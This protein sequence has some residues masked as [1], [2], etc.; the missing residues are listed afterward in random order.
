MPKALRNG[1]YKY[2]RQRFMFYAILV[3]LCVKIVLYLM[4]TNLSI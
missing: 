2:I 4:S 1:V 3:Y